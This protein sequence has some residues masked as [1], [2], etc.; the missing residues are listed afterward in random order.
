MQINRVYKVKTHWIN[1]GR[2]YWLWSQQQN[3]PEAFE[4]TVKVHN[5]IKAFITRW[6]L[7][8]NFPRVW[9]RKRGNKAKVHKTRAMWLTES[10]E[11]DKDR[12]WNWLTCW[13]C[14]NKAKK[15]KT[16]DEKQWTI[17]EGFSLFSLALRSKFPT[18]SSSSAAKLSWPAYSFLLLL[19]S[20]VTHLMNDWFY[21]RQSCEWSDRVLYDE[22][23]IYTRQGVGDSVAVRWSSLYSEAP[24]ARDEMYLW[25]VCIFIS[26]QYYNVSCL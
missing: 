13:V 26:S 10:S 3:S 7:I 15:K 4:W 5:N 16:S 17:S 21:I 20:H 22:S 9:G 14:L 8:Q 18:K 24:V 25:L 12:W 1:N 6:K 23:S 11:W 2:N 19:L